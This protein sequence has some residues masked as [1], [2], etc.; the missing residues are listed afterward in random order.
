MADTRKYADLRANEYNTQDTYGTR[1]RADGYNVGTYSY[2]DGLGVRADLQHYVTFFINVRGKSKFVQNGAYKTNDKVSPSAIAGT[3]IRN[4]LDNSG[5]GTSAVYGAAVAAGIYTIGKGV[6]GALLGAASSA[7]GAAGKAAAGNPRTAAA[8]V[9]GLAALGLF[10]LFLGE[11]GAQAMAKTQVL[12]QDQTKRL[13]DVITLHM[14]ERPAVSYGINYQDKDL[15][16]LGGLLGVDSAMSESLNAGSFATGMAVNMALQVAKV[17]SIIPGLGSIT[18]IVQLAGKVK[19][20]PFREVFFEGI[21]YRKFNFKYKFMPKSEKE[22]MA[23]YNIIDKFKEHM[24]PEIAG[25]GAFFL[26][27]SEF[28]I[29]YYYNSKENGYFNKIAACAL[30]DMSVEYGGDQFSTFSNGAPTE[31]NLTLSFRELELITKESIK[32]RGY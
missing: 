1:L 21:D 18:D 32:S 23:I 7:A 22:V 29:A 13:Q 9:G 19:T 4:T 6:S 14:Q 31:I 17:P 26:Y 25:G 30:T 24:H 28:E 27:P 15:G 11:A 3:S 5:V 20:N 12:Q 2:P 8:K 16:I 10:G